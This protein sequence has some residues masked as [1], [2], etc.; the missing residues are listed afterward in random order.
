M[1]KRPENPTAFNARYQLKDWGCSDALL[2][3]AKHDN[4]GGEDR[5]ADVVCFLISSLNVVLFVEPLGDKDF[6]QDRSIAADGET[7]YDGKIKG[8]ANNTLVHV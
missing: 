3:G 5:S 8:F 2:P 6:P 7:R 1:M 4:F